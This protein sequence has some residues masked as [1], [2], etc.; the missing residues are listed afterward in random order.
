LNSA[1]A[2][3]QAGAELVREVAKETR[4][5]VVIMERMAE[6]MS[7]IEAAYSELQT[8]N[9]IIQSITDKTSIIHDIVFKSQLLS[10]NAS[11]EAA[12]AGEYGRGFAIVAAE[13][14]KLSHLSGD[15][16]DQIKELLDSSRQK[17]VD[18]IH[19]T[20]FSIEDCRI[21]SNS[22]SKKF[23]QLSR[24]ISELE[25]RFEGISLNSREK[26]NS[27]LGPDSSVASLR[28]AIGKNESFTSEAR[29]LAADIENQ[30]IF[31]Q[32]A[33][34]YTMQILS[35]EPHTVSEA[36]SQRVTNSDS[37]KAV[38]VGGGFLRKKKGESKAV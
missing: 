18:I 23:D 29:Q 20:H 13:V 26:V 16:A 8:I 2:E 9:N 5:G 35:V 7:S 11:I 31:I 32:K 17:V 21:E 36:T 38:T 37:D 12:R 28:E 6:A 30:L 27:T 25:A 4:E 3:A 24:Q 10:F 15:A 14:G 19:M 34:S 1:S 33:T 22:A